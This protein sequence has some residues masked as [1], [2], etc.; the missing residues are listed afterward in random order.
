MKI[1]RMVGVEAI[2]IESK[3]RTRMMT[4]MMMTMKDRKD[5]PVLASAKHHHHHDLE[6]ILQ[7][8]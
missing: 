7:I 2:G 4:R 8:Q 1:R 5:F 3:K 6:T